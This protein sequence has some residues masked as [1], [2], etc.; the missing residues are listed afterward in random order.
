VDDPNG[1]RFLIVFNC[2]A[3]GAAFEKPL[4]AKSEAVQALRAFAKWFWRRAE[5]ITVKLQLAQPLCLGLGRSDRDG[6][7][8]T[9]WGAKRSFF[10]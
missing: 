4:R 3:T 8:T 6:A 1:F 7:F 10:R 2:T 9:T 5:G